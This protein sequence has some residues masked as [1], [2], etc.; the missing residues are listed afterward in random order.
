MAIAEEI[1]AR[2]PAAEM[3]ARSQLKSWFNGLMN[4]PNV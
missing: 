2:P 1:A 3:L 4:K